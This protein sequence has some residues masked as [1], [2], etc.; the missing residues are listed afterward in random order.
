[1]RTLLLALGSC[2]RTLRHLNQIQSE[3][4]RKTHLLLVRIL[5]DPSRTPV[6][7]SRSK[8]KKSTL[9]RTRLAWKR[10]KASP[11]PEGTT[12]ARPTPSSDCNYK[13]PLSQYPLKLGQTMDFHNIDAANTDD[14]E[15]C[16]MWNGSTR[17]NTACQAPT[18]RDS[19]SPRTEGCVPS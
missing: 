17:D 15:L 7:S 9:R 5:L 16:K 6:G 13:G 19:R 4:R 3:K 11:W 10:S 12:L 1:M 8:T 18:L 2:T 14:L